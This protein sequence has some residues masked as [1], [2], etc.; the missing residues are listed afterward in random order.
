MRE[1]IK[2]IILQYSLAES[3]RSDDTRL[4]EDLGIDSLR[5]VELIVALE[6][7]FFVLFDENN[8]SPDRLSTVEDIYQLLEGTA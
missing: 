8:L 1:K 2:Q 4:K 7:I 5:L 3:Y 6:D